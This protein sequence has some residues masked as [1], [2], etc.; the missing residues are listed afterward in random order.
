MRIII[1]GASPKKSFYDIY[2][3]NPSDYFIGVDA[4]SLEIIKR[5]ITPDISIGD[6]DSTEEF[7]FI[8]AN[9]HK[10]ITYSSDKDDTDLE[11][12]IKLLEDLKGSNNLY[13]DIYDVTGERLDHEFNAYMLLAKYSRYKLRILDKNN[14]VM[15]LKENSEYMLKTRKC[16][17]FSIFAKEESI[18]NI[19]NAKYN[20]DNVIINSNDTYTI[21]NEL[22]HDN[23][24]PI[25]EVKK[26]GVFLFV[27]YE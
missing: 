19:I 17:Y 6:F 18:V 23:I 26:G 15:F 3:L 2:H 14:E 8:E 9:S 22:M 25:I 27:Y 20:L 24:S 16:K 5:S 12:A 4:G 11:L 13:V 1:V 21:S 10:V 7:K